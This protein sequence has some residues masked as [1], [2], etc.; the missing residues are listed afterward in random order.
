M[1]CDNDNAR[2]Q[3]CKLVLSAN[4]LIGDSD[5]AFLRYGHGIGPT[6]VTKLEREAQREKEIENFGFSVSD[7]VGNISG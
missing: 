6:S 1:S 7:M 2:I 4:G 5:R 3:A